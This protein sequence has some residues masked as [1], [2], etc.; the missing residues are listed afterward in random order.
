MKKLL[1][2]LFIPLLFTCS[3]D[4]DNSNQISNDDDLILCTSYTRQRMNSNTEDYIW[5]ASATYSGSKTISSSYI[6]Y[7]YNSATQSVDEEIW[8]KNHI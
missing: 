8:Y 1:L 7:T 5:T 3:S 4:D 6:Q 2:L